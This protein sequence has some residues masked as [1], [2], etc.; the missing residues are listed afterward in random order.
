[1]SADAPALL[2]SASGAAHGSLTPSAAGLGS[3]DLG[4]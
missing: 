3:S 4:F 2:P 1:M